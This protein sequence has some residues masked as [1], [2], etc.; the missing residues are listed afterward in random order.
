MPSRKAPHA[1][2][3]TSRLC[4]VCAICCDGTLFH[5]VELQPGDSPDRLRA[6]GLPLRRRPSGRG[7][8]F[9]QPCAA[10]DG[11]LCTLYKDRPAYCRRFDCALLASVRGGRLS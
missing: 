9:A 8:R 10:L 5:A 6:L 1:E 11:C 3:P 2:D 7:T 4:Q